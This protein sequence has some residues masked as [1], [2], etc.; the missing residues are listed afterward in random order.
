MAAMSRTCKD[1]DGDRQ[2]C[3]ELRDATTP[4]GGRMPPVRVKQAHAH[5]G[6][7]NKGQED[8]TT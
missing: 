6:Q 3:A 4:V 1:Q 7:A 5:S 2:G 8:P